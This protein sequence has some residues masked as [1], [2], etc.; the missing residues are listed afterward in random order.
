MHRD[1]SVSL[2][3]GLLEALGRSIVMGEFQAGGFPT[4]AELCLRYQASRTVAREAVK[5]LTAKR[6]VSSRPRQGTRVEPVETWN[7]LD[8]DVT[9]WMTERPY[10]NQIYRDLTEVRLAVEP[11]GAALAAR[12]ATKADIKTIRLALNSMR[13]EADDHDQALLAD[14]DFHV[15]ILKASGN[16]F[17]IQLKELIHMALTISIGL[18]NR[19]A[20]HTA[21]IAAHEAVLLA[22]EARDPQAAE[23]AMRKILIESLDLLDALNIETQSLD[24][25]HLGGLHAD[26]QIQ[27]SA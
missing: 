23:A 2:T 26:I 4:E 20:G 10:N 11:V 17:M 19:I 1:R 8:P 7:L 21:S 12:R 27:A 22:I 3:Y 25:Q 16:P 14:I 15:A 9:R 24:G 13:D 18:T 6:L 5:M